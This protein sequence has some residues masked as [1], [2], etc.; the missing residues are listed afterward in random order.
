M[1]LL[2]GTIGVLILIVWA[3]TIFDIF[4]RHLGGKQTT[5][6]LVLVIILPFIGSLIYWATRKESAEDVES[7]VAADAALR[8]EN[9]S[10][11]VDSTRT[12]L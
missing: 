9:R 4:R 12:R 7:Y 10:Q 8:A 3:I 2:W 5:L 1:G 11:S 6:W